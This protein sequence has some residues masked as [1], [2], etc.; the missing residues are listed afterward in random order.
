MKIE[1]LR[2]TI[3]VGCP[4]HD[5]FRL[6]TEATSTW[7]PA[8]HTVSGRAGVE[9]FFE[10]RGGG[11]I[12]ERSPTGE[13]A[14]WG[15][16]TPWGSTPPSGLSLAYPNR[17]R[18]ATDVAIE[19]IDQGDRTTRVEIEHGGW[20]RL[21]NRGPGWRDTN[22]AGWD[23]ALPVYVSACNRTGLRQSR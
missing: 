17:S 3:T 16:I 11:R 21:G 1:P 5:A 13:E 23:G 18:S 12:F 2:F 9:V 20:E 7:W 19:F 22:R 6:W 10:G 4:V 14:E 8:S 15:V